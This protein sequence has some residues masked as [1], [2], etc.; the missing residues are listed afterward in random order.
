MLIAIIDDGIITS[1]LNDIDLAHDLSVGLDGSISNRRESET[2]LSDHG[3][4]CA[5]IILKYTENATFCSLR[6]FHDEKLKTS[7]DALI[8]S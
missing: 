3:T 4:S 6:I 2:I 1:F 5:A 7:A 8:S